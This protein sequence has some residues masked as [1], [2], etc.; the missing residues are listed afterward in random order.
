MSSVSRY[1]LKE[2]GKSLTT[3]HYAIDYLPC[4][5]WKVKYLTFSPFSDTE[6]F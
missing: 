2:H 6:G 5:L 3:E 4:G 1:S